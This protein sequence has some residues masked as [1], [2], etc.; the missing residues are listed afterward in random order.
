VNPALY[1]LTV[2]NTGGEARDLNIL[3]SLPNNVFSYDNSFTPQVALTMADNT[4]GTPTG[5]DVLNGG[6][7]PTFR[8]ATLPAGARVSI[9]FQATIASTAND[10]QPYQASAGVSYLNPLRSAADAR[11]QNSVNY[12]ADDNAYGTPAGT[13]YAGANP[14]NTFEDVTIT[15]PLPVEL[16]RFEVVAEKSDARLN[17]TTASER[18]NDRFEI[19]RC[20]DGRTFE[21]VGT[22]R[23]QGTSARP[24]AY[25]F[26][27]AGVARL[28][29]LA[30]Y[31]L[32]QIDT[33]G[34]E[35][36][37]PVRVVTFP[38][39]ATPPANVALYPNPTP[40]QTTLDL[41]QLPAG[42][43]Q[44][45]VLDLTGRELGRYALEGAG[46]HPLRV[47]HLLR[48]SYVV[49]VLGNGVSLALPLVRN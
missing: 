23:G 32:R 2:S 13:D 30:Y 27:D 26:T 12:Y 33:D 29:A 10:G 4:A 20:F 15:R 6:S 42:T 17:W 19:E 39:P 36:V 18:G 14:E 40:G 37:S 25:R 24:T 1:T 44:V 31:R 43:Y 47:Q 11:I 45:R 9:T 35:S 38:R 5:F 16:T 34:T 8:L 41:R 7:I 21:R 22:V 48:G 46:Q 3:T 49:R 28:G